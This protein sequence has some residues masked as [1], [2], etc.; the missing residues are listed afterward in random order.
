M[1]Q[2]NTSNVQTQSPN[3]LDLYGSLPCLDIWLGFFWTTDSGFSWTCFQTGT[4]INKYV[5]IDDSESNLS[6]TN[7]A[8]SQV[9]CK[10]LYTVSNMNGLQR[11][12]EL[13]ILKMV[14]MHCLGPP[15]LPQPPQW[16]PPKKVYQG[17]GNPH[18]Q[19]KGI[20]VTLGLIST[21]GLASSKISPSSSPQLSQQ[22]QLGSAQR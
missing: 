4:W 22:W 17:I 20:R 6:I 10:L 14:C 13:W 2:H 16:S 11:H 5:D 1:H 8:W 21:T 3:M 18:Q 7:N 12:T 9:H 19:P 15:I